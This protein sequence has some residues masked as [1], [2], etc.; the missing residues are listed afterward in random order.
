MKINYCFKGNGEETVLFLHGW[1][2]NL[3]S[4]FFYA[5]NLKQHFKTLQIDFCGFGESES[6]TYPLTV[7]DYACEVYRLIKTLKLGRITIVCHSFG[8]RVAI[9]L[10]TIFNMDVTN[11]II[12]GG[13]GIKPRFNIFN[14]IKIYKYKFLKLLNKC[15]LFNF[16]L[17]NF[18]SSDYKALNAVQKQ[19]FVN[20]VN[21]NEKKYL[22]NIKANT[23]LLW[24][25]KDDST[26]V[27][28]AKIF[29]KKIKNSK[30]KV[31]KGLG[32]FCFLENKILTLFEIKSFLDID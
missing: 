5:E 23:L 16:N 25:E 29:N 15:K 22:K 27:Y 1:G 3:N 28:M 32:H 14:K 30:L 9:L 17:N 2:A 11:L 13:A 20:V 18:G 21:F 26:P 24:G 8:A 31:F 7:F 4:F 6:L 12:I 19:T 10:S